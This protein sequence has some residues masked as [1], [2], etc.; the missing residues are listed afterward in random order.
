M[1]ARKR[2]QDEGSVKGRR[3]GRRGAKSKSRVNR[4]Q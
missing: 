3:E 4:R 2:A 1:H